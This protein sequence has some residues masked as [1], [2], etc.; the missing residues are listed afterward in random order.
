MSLVDD[1]ADPTRRA[2][3]VLP[4]VAWRAVLPA[5]AALAAVLSAL[6]NGYG[7]DRDELYFRML[8]PAWGYVDQPP[9]TPLLARLT[10][11]I[12][13]DPAALRIP[14]TVA[15]TLSV[16]VLVLITREVGGGP[17]F[18]AVS[19]RSKVRQQAALPASLYLTVGGRACPR[20]EAL[21][22]GINLQRSRR[23]LISPGTQRV[24]RR[25]VTGRNFPSSTNP[26]TL[27]F[28]GLQRRPT[29]AINLEIVRALLR[30]MT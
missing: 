14:A 5:L 20:T 11:H 17:P 27:E 18:S 22:D 21:R 8:A 4:G 16:L 12:S 13:A 7:F 19:G 23:E 10:A 30:R 9:L 26:G 25:F 24:R 2:Q 6:S 3:V 1:S 29:A 28:A 15:A